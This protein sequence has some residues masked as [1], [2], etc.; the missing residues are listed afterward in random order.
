MTYPSENWCITRS[1]FRM[2]E[3]TGNEGIRGFYS[4][5]RPDSSGRY[6]EEIWAFTDHQLEYTHDYIQWL[7]PLG[8]RSRFNPDAPLLTQQT[9]LAFR[10]SEFLKSRLKRSI[11]LMLKFYGLQSVESKIGS[12]KI[13]KS[14]EFGSKSLNWLELQN[15]NHLRL[16]RIMTS[17]GFLGL[18]YYS[19][20]MLA[21]LEEIAAEHPEGFSAQTLQIWRDAANR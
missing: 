21:C 20:A 11:E 5:E 2:P 6:I 15:H 8:T 16:T 7:F 17:A 14:P 19:M 3:N 10:R 12:L 18:R 4:G 13:V 1:P 9:I